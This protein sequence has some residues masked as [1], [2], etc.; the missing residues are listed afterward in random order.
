MSMRT[1][2]VFLADHGNLR[3]RKVDTKGTVTTIAGTGVQ[4]YDGR[5][6]ARD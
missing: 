3:V 2:N 5:R 1:G 6:R 4:G